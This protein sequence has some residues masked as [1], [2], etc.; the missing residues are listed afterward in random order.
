MAAL[1]GCAIC[2]LFRRRRRKRGERKR[3]SIKWPPVD[4]NVSF[5]DLPEVPPMHTISIDTHKK[6]SVVWGPRP[7]S[8][9]ESDFGGPPR[10]VS[11]HTPNKPRSIGLA[12]IGAGGI[13][14]D[15]DVGPFSDLHAMPGRG[16]PT[17]GLAVSAGQEV[18]R[19]RTYS[20]TPSSPSLYPESMKTAD[21]N[22]D[23]LY[24]REM[25]I[26]TQHDCIETSRIAEYR[27]LT[28]PASVSSGS[29]S[30]PLTAKLPKALRSVL[31]DGRDIPLKERQISVLTRR[32]LL[33]VR[34]PDHDFWNLNLTSD[35]RFVP[36]H[37]KCKF[38]P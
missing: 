15:Q 22:A 35:G 24:E 17:T 4:S 10:P 20:Y 6:P 33:N 26:S 29:S 7:R 8:T 38:G 5:S 19:M 1:M 9:A 18:V 2:L 13:S 12:G 25:G 21:E 3:A 32:S 36:W 16:R 28:P 34:Y 30:V 23:S 27:P 37:L 11:A 31:D 14:I